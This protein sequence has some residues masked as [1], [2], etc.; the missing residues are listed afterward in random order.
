[1]AWE[2]HSDFSS[3]N[4]ASLRYDDVT[5]TLEVTFLSGAVYQYYDVPSNI[6]DGLKNAGSKGTFMHQSVKGYYRYSRV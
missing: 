2:I 4:I 1:M 5:S 6:W 3:S